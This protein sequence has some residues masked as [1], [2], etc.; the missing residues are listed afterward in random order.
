MMYYNNQDAGPQEKPEEVWQDYS[1]VHHLEE[2]DIDGGSGDIKDSTGNHNGTTEGINAAD[3]VGGQI[4]GSMDFSAGSDMDVVLPDSSD[5]TLDTTDN[6][7]IT[8]WLQ[9]AGDISGTYA[10]VFGYHS[11][12]SVPATTYFSGTAE[13]EAR[14]LTGTRSP[15]RLAPGTTSRWSGPAKTI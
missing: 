4:D 3:Q 11:R 10:N 6:V 9:F 8:A 13:A 14:R 2:T 7:T 15:T 12:G 5:W 1:M